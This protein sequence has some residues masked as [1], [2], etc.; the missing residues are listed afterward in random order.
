VNKTKVLGNEL[1]I[2]AASEPFYWLNLN[3]QRE[4][5]S[6]STK[7]ILKQTPFNIAKDGMM[8]MHELNMELQLTHLE[9]ENYLS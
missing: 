4:M 9:S 2:T 1:N 5:F 3:I 6:N 7:L 8:N